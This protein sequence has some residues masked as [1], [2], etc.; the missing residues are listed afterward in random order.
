MALLAGT[1]YDPGTIQSR[2]LAVLSA[3]AAMDT[4]NLRLTFTAPSNGAVLVRIK[5]QESGNSVPGYG[6]LGVMSGATVVARKAAMGAAPNFVTNMAVGQEAV[7]VVPGLTPGNSYTWDAAYST[8]IATGSTSFKYGGPDASGSADAFG[9]IDFEIWETPNLLG[10]KFYDPGTAASQSL[11]SAL[12]MTAM[13]TTNLRI[14][15]TAPSTGTVLWRI[16]ACEHGSTTMGTILMGI[17]DG[18]T[19]RARTAPIA[20]TPS[21]LSATSR[22]ALEASGVITGIS[23]GM[24]YTWDAAYSVETVSAGSAI[25]YGGPD[26]T[27]TDNAFGGIGFEIWSA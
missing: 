12:A 17:L 16:A 11:A 26:D 6:L 18:S 22:V 4:T 27:T 20:A 9:S 15:F 13:D 25:K 2:S 3:M 14:T 8:E 24:S 21:N 7:F 1:S 23:P 19:V 10:A 5:A